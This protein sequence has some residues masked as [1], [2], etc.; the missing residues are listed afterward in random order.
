MVL[1]EIE[2]A[3]SLLDR[4]RRLFGKKPHKLEAVDNIAARF[5]AIFENHGVHRNQIP[6][7]FQHGLTI[8]DVANDEKLLSVLTEKMLNDVCE[9]FAIRREWLDGVDKQIYP[10]HSFYKEPERFEAFILSLTQRQGDRL[11]GKLIISREGSRKQP[12]LMVFYEVADYIGDKPIYRYY[13]CCDESFNYWKAR[14]YLTACV[15][16]AWK[17]RIYIKGEDVPVSVIDYY[18]GGKAFLPSDNNYAVSIYSKRWHPEEMAME[19][20]VYLE[21]MDPEL[22][23]HGVKAGLRLWLDLANQGLMDTC[24]SAAPIDKFEAE[25]IKYT[26]PK[27]NYSNLINQVF[28]RRDSSNG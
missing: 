15:A 17:H 25:L 7:F 16:T 27:W 21:G 4:L 13:L 8:A 11:T 26:A 23:N 24:V 12:S 18:S 22:N 10:L 1:G 2:S 3:L 28:G 20:N 5:I 9:L 6:R 14:G 19:P